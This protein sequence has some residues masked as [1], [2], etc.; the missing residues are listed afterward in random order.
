MVEELATFLHLVRGR[1]TDAIVC[2]EKAL[3]FRESLG[4]H[5]YISR[6]AARYLMIAHAAL[7]NYNDVD[8][9]FDKLFLGVDLVSQPPPDLPIYLFYAGR[10][11]WLQGRI[12]E[13]RKIFD[14]ICRHLET[15]AIADA[16]EMR[17][18]KI[19]MESLVKIAEG[20]F[21]GAELI[22]CQ[23]EVQ[24][25][26]DRGSRVHGDTRLMLARLY[27]LQNLKRKALVQLEPVFADYKESGIPYAFILEGQSI[28][29]LLRHAV[30][31]G[32]Y[33]QYAT[34]LLEILAVGEVVK[35]IPIPETGETLT[36]REAEILTLVKAGLSNRQIAEE[37]V[38]SVWTVKSHLTK[39]Y[40]KLDVTSR[41]QAI[42]R[43]RELG[44]R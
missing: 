3:A 41:T 12:K 9:L 23:T 11:R 10:I 14:Q 32:T 42:A 27:W 25:I 6:D 34:D 7:G 31:K 24:L 21:K 17:I 37:L 13:A 22:L 29:P 40:R 19:W 44:L 33:Q 36:T 8:P 5:P 15:N 43:S 39:I 30:R 2:G 4:G 20:N 16:P 18:C 38:I 26:H 28:V 1:L 35:P